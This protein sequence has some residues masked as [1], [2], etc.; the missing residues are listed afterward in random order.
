MV[1]I[2]AVE[3]SV[4]EMEVDG[5]EGAPDV[6]DLYD[7]NY[8]SMTT[9]N[10][11]DYPMMEDSNPAPSGALAL[12]PPTSFADTMV[13]IPMRNVVLGS[14]LATQI[15]DDDTQAGA[16]HRAALQVVLASNKTVANLAKK[17]IMERDSSVLLHS[18]IHV[19]RI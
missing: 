19:I 2:S 4:D 17:D 13:P 3:I 6:L 16:M 14:N 18:S 7:S 15:D 5:Y 8:G 11:N 9:F 12:M 1:L 10:L